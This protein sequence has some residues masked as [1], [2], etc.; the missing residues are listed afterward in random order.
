MNVP[1]DEMMVYCKDCNGF[2]FS[3]YREPGSPKYK[4]ISCPYGCTHDSNGHVHMKH[5]PN[6]QRYGRS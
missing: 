6:G 1:D 3:D 5:P 2:L 4:L